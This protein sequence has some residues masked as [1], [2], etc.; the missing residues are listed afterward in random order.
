[1]DRQN[2][3]C[4]AWTESR[5]NG[6]DLTIEVF[7]V[8]KCVMVLRNHIWFRFYAAAGRMSSLISYEDYRTLFETVRIQKA[9][10]NGWNAEF[11]YH[12]DDAQIIFKAHDSDVSERT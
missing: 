4:I 7:T 11:V 5:L 10:A 6:E 8:D 2:I 3:V 1:M 9:C 12:G